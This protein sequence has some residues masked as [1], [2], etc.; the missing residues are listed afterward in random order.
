MAGALWPGL[1]HRS[2]Q[3]SLRSG[4]WYDAKH[5]RK[6]APHSSCIWAAAVHSPTDTEYGQQ[7]QLRCAMRG[8]TGLRKRAAPSGCGAHRRLVR[9]AASGG[10]R[11]AAH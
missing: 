5:K 4:I 9:S 7:P 11:V 6:R 1:S 8:S 3:L 2:I 10:E